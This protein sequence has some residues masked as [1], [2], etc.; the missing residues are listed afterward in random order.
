[1]I[2]YYVLINS[3]NWYLTKVT[4]SSFRNIVFNCH[5]KFDLKFTLK[6]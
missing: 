1:M 5:S 4:S 2:M 6:V 3:K